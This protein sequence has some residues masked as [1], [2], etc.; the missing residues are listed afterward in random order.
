MA[1]NNG[2]G[3]KIVVAAIIL[4]FLVFIVGLIY[5]YYRDEIRKPAGDESSVPAPKIS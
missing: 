3:M 1:D 2:S 4:S 5:V